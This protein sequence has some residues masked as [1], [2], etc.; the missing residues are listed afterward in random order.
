MCKRMKPDHYLI[1]NTKINSKW[2]KELNIKPETTRLL[3]ENIDGLTQVLAM[4]F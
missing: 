4:I 3:E 1:P 2:I